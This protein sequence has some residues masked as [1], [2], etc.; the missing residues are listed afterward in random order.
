M[1][2][3]GRHHDL[4]VWKL[5][6]ALGPQF[7][8]VGRWSVEASFICSPISFPLHPLNGSLLAQNHQ[9]KF[10]AYPPASTAPSESLQP[11]LLLLSPAGYLPSALQGLGKWRASSVMSPWP[12]LLTTVQWPCPTAS[13]PTFITREH[14]GVVNSSDHSS[15]SQSSQKV[16]RRGT[17]HLTHTHVC[18]YPPRVYPPHP[19]S[20]K[21][22]GA[23]ASQWP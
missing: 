16:H 4:R 8:W 3:L 2:L 23:S 20:F 12:A 18:V 17:H 19:L 22:P 5:H 7:R 15:F 10:L 13:V 11:P 21:P 14:E 9:P 1:E 6:R